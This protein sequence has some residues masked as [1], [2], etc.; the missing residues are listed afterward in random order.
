LHDM[1]TDTGKKSSLVNGQ[2]SNQELQ[3]SYTTNENEAFLR[4]K[5]DPL[6]LIK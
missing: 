4:M 6:V 2:K 3:E 1:D 5:E